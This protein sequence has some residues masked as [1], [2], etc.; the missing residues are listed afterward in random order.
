MPM[1]VIRSSRRVVGWQIADPLG[2]AAG[3]NTDLYR[4]NKNIMEFDRSGALGDITNLGLTLAERKQLLVLVRQEN[5]A[6]QIGNYAILQPAS[7][8]CGARC[9]VKD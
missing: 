1:S 4:I 7:R 5:V 8:T 6:A 9:R 3:W 2:F